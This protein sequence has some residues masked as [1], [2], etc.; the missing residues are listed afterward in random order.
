MNILILSMI[1]H[2]KIPKIK[3]NSITRKYFDRITGLTMNIAINIA[4]KCRILLNSF[5]LLNLIVYN[6]LY[7]KLFYVINIIQN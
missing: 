2:R 7:L 1:I 3:P 4:A 5:Y 6:L